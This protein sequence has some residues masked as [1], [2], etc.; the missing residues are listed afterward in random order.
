M[1]TN[2]PT[3]TPTADT[4]EPRG[5]SRRELM[6]RSGWLVAA[7]LAASTLELP[8][9]AR[10]EGGAPS[11]QVGA[12]VDRIAADPLDLPAPIRRT[13]PKHHDITLTTE[14]ATAEIEPGV[15]FDYMTFGGRVPGPMIR[16]RQGD[17]VSLTLKHGSGVMPHNIDL[18]AV[19]GPGGGA[20]DT[21]VNVGQSKTIEFQARYPGA[22]IYHCAVAGLLDF[23]ISAG[24]FGMILVEPEDGLPAVDREYYLGQHE[25]YTDRPTGEKGHHAFSFDAMTRENPSYVLLNGEKY[26]LTAGARGAL[27]AQVGETAR[28]FFVNGGPNL[29]SSFHPIGN[30]WTRA[31][32]EG[33]LLNTPERYLQTVQVAPGSTAVTE[34]TFPV[35]GPVKLVDHALTRVARK[36]MLGIIDV[37]GDPQ[38]AIF[39]PNPA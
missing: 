36:G 9:F 15:T 32:R 34:L 11:A 10:A 28:V 22:F 20:A 26:A 31:W 37:A 24:M 21:L 8:S 17:T 5:L 30:V 2:A 14:E 6:R 13:S 27:P 25:I 35:P 19:Y 29:T 39:D 16:V 1:H 23:H 38:P 7:G 33:G 12:L 3:A 4:D 18:H